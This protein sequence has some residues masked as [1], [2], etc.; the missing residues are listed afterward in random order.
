MAPAEPGGRVLHGPALEAWLDDPALEAYLRTAV[1]EMNRLPTGASQRASQFWRVE[2]RRVERVLGTIHAGG[3]AAEA[4]AGSD[5]PIRRIV[6]WNV[7][8]GIAFDEIVRALQES[9]PLRAPDV[10]LLNEVDVGMARSGNRHVAAELATRLGM[11]WA[12]APSYLELTKGAGAE[13][14]VPGS[15]RLGLHGVA[16]LTRA[17]PLAL[18]AV[19]LPESF[20]A[21]AFREK[22]YGRRTA[23]L[24]ALG[25][26]R[27]V[28][29]AHLEVRGTPLG[30]WAQIR[31]LLDGLDAFAGDEALQGRVVREVVLGGDLNTHTFARGTWRGAIAGGL[32]V[33]LTPPG[34]LRRQL[35]EPW[36][37]GREPLFAE[38]RRAGFEWASLNDGRPTASETLDRIEEIDLLPAA[39]RRPMRALLHRRVP[40][41][42]DWF[43]ARGLPPDGPPARAATVGAWPPGTSPSDHLPIAIELA[44]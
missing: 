37:R 14:H 21:F 30:R 29:G 26:G 38:L 11:H 9:G 5:G 24:A 16:I 13:A 42:L 3:P 15:N 19:A 18:R 36:R 10:L 44:R 34:R 8:K 39:L 22:R 2:E 12:F 33:A 35:L 40:L 23:L 6:H 31:A 17:R 1:A 41:R 43:A 25:Q 4:P 28:A 20:D 7:L 32:R 27:V